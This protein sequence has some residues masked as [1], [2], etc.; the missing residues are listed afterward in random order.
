VLGV[1]SK[2]V[3]NSASEDEF[4]GSEAYVRQL[5]ARAFGRPF[6]KVRPNFSKA[7]SWMGIAK[8]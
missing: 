7:W 4:K 8:S 5:F 3:F 2:E 6:I 1:Y